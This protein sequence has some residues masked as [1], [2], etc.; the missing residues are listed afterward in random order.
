ME[1]EALLGLP[2]AIEAVIKIRSYIG[3]IL[4]SRPIRIPGVG[5][6]LPLNQ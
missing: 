1:M 4:T 5:S 6:H 2:E 3:N